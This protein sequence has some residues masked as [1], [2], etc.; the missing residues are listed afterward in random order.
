MILFDVTILYNIINLE[1]CVYRLASACILKKYSST[2]GT[3]IL[4]LVAPVI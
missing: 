3:V 4:G 2:H 1:S